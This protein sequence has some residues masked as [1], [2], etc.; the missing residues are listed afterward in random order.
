MDLR[1][2]AILFAAYAAISLFVPRLLAEPALVSKR[3]GFVLTAW[4]ISLSVAALSL[5]SALVGLIALAVAQHSEEDFTSS[6]FVPILINVF[7]WVAL[8]AL[9]IL[10]FRFIAAL[11][12]LKSARDEM[13][14]R[15]ALV[16]PSTGVSTINGHAVALV[17]SDQPLL[18][19]VPSARYI[20]LSTHLNNTLNPELLHAALAHEQ[21]HLDQRHGI[22]R[23]AGA[24]AMAVAPGFS[25]SE[26]M[27]Q[28]T[29]ITT[30]LLADDA[31][32]QKFSKQ[33]VAQALRAC[34]GSSPLIDERVARL[35]A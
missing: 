8:G 27:A 19:A 32:A 9:G 18:M 7:G 13:A 2:I 3:P 34:F 28:A 21:A 24:L 31:A 5:L 26:Q 10:A 23:A 17:V 14:Q 4:L 11:S 1:T 16:V 29:R 33:T 12:E 25:A 30:E 15:I 6:I 22:I 20:L 35:E